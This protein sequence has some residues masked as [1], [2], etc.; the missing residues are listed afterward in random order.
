M[1]LKYQYYPIL[2]QTT[3]RLLELQAGVLEEPLICH[4]AL[5]SLDCNP[6]YEALSYC[7]GDATQKV[8]LLCDE[9]NISITVNLS[10][11]LRRLR[12][13]DGVRVLWADA[14]C[15]NQE[16]LEERG[17]QVKLMG[18]IYRKASTTFVWLGH[19]DERHAEA[20][21]ELCMEIANGKVTRSLQ[22][23]PGQERRFSIEEFPEYCEEK[24]SH[25]PP[26]FQCPWFSRMWV[27]QEVGLSK[28]VV[29]T[30]GDA[31]IL[32][33]HFIMVPLLLDGVSSLPDV[34]SGIF[35]PLQMKYLFGP[36]LNEGFLEALYRAQLFLAT[37]PRD[38]I[39]GLLAHPTACVGPEGQLAV[40]PN[41]TKSWQQVYLEFANNWIE[42]RNNLEILSAVR[43]HLGG[44]FMDDSFP[45]WV[46]CWDAP[47]GGMLGLFEA[48]YKASGM[49]PHNILPG[50]KLETLLRVRGL[51][52]GIVREHSGPLLKTDLD[53]S[54]QELNI[55]LTISRGIKESF[56]EAPA[57]SPYK[58]GS[59][60]MDA[61]ILSLSANMHQSNL[62]RSK[63]DQ[64]LAD[65]QA[66]W[67]AIRNQCIDLEQASEICLDMPAVY[68]DRAL[69]GQSPSWAFHFNFG[70]LN[71][72]FFRLDNGY[73]G[74]G[75]DVLED[76]DICCV[77]FG[78]KVPFIIRPCGSYFRL[79]GECYVH[80]I[81]NGEAMEMWKRNE[82]L[83]EGFELR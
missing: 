43:H 48:D 52:F 12:K 62:S 57:I 13:P 54:E 6:S 83:Q 44:R 82:I 68:E 74:V 33:I 8:D 7:W 10:N 51:R 29:L 31:E 59:D 2:D 36:A 35:K 38:K 60:H 45:S 28:R 56:Y 32:W 25:L 63:L 21:F 64:H 22:G 20:A 71:R 47:G 42:H 4:M 24:F 78:A 61:Y 80:G 11:A 65:F 53:Y 15:I 40:E 26:L 72:S 50:N 18:S 1:S 46:P 76:G 37:D 67:T 73:V 75:Q 17:Q 58:Q 39:F 27:I 77:L 5:A 34:F 9:K 79:V 23:E 19:D 55:W 70:C 14:A 3:I 30:W 81:M 66:W 16:D 49:V 69:R 41:Y